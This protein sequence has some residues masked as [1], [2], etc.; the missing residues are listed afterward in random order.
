MKLRTPLALPAFLICLLLTCAAPPLSAEIIDHFNTTTNINAGNDGTSEVLT[1]TSTAPADMPSI[2]GV[3][4]NYDLNGGNYVYMEKKYQGSNLT[5]GDSIKFSYAGTGSANNIEFK[6]TDANSVTYFTK[7]VGVTNTGGAWNTVVIPFTALTQWVSGSPTIDYTNISRFEFAV[8]KDAGGAGLAAISNLQLYQSNNPLS[9]LA[10][11]CNTNTNAIGNVVGDWRQYDTG[12]N[13]DTITYIIETGT[14]SPKGD[15]YYGITYVFN[16]AHADGACVQVNDVK[17]RSGGVV[18]SSLNVTGLSYVTFYLRGE[19][20]GEKPRFDLQYWG[21]GSGDNIGRLHVKLPD[22]HPVTTSWQLYSIPLSDFSGLNTARLVE[23][24]IE[25][26]QAD[27]GAGFSNGK[28]Y[29]DDIRFTAQA[30]PNSIT[31]L[32]VIRTLDNMTNTIGASSSWNFS[33]DSNVDVTYYAGSG[34]FVGYIVADYSFAKGG[35][36]ISMNRGTGANIFNSKGLRFKYAGSGSANNLEFKIIDSNNTAYFRKYFGVT[37]TSSKWKTMVVPLK[38]FVP[39]D[40]ASTASLDMKSITT[41]NYAISKKAGGTGSFCIADLELIDDPDF[42]VDVSGFNM[43]SS[44]KIPENP[45]SPNNDGVKDSARFMYT[46]KD[47]ATVKLEIFNMNGSIV[48]GKE[49]DDA[50]DGAEHTFQWLCQDN[51]GSLVRNGLYF[52]KFTVKG[53]DGL[54]DKITH[55]IGV[56]R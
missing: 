35:S 3:Q 44:F 49:I 40:S 29:L 38:E 32:G 51:D 18:V 26:N 9:T 13:R 50:Y 54:E 27:I 23:C 22:Y 12:V 4:L 52:Y 53:Y 25:F 16:G 7:L 34:S 55:V 56:I 14:P 42:Q 39:F 20:G 2:Q 31:G 24:N 37:N 47:S 6:L 48:Y 21:S 15:G 19:N 43:L 28:V 41:F 36:W 46:L 5:D 10:N 45:V 8:S 1:F 30:D 11:D 33:A 17:T